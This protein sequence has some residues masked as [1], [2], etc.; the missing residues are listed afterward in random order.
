MACAIFPVAT[1]ELQAIRP[2]IT[3]QAFTVRQGA[4]I[5][6]NCNGGLL[7]L[8]GHR[9]R[10]V[11]RLVETLLDQDKY[12]TLDVEVEFAAERE[13]P[14]YEITGAAA[15]LAAK[16]GNT[17]AAIRMLDNAM[18]ESCHLLELLRLKCQIAFEYATPGVAITALD[19]LCRRTPDDAAAWHNLGTAY[20][21]AGCNALARISYEKSL[22]LRPD[23]ALTLLQLEALSRHDAAGYARDGASR[24]GNKPPAADATLATLEVTPMAVAAG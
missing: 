23:S 2:G 12:V 21:R 11:A 19:E 20:Q 9:I 16:R 17:E 10:T 4:L 5:C 8:K 18:T 22:A 6:R 3:W 24:I 14:Q 7:S 1:V 15:R 13:I